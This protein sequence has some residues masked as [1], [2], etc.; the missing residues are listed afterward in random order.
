MYV[1]LP[2]KRNKKTMKQSMNNTYWWRISR[3]I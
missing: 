3:F 2:T 1:L